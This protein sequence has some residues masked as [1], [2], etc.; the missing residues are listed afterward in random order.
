M[1]EMSLFFEERKMLDTNLYAIRH[2]PQGRFFTAVTL[3]TQPAYSRTLRRVI[4]T[5]ISAG[6]GSFL[7]IAIT[8]KSVIVDLHNLNIYICFNKLLVKL[9]TY[10]NRI[11]IQIHN[12]GRLTI[13]SYF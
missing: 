10:I 11:G 4:L 3:G 12:K 9:L 6:G 1:Q 8:S 2:V 13:T 7:I 5:F